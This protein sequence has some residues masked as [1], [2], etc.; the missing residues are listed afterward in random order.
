M[1]KNNYFILVWHH[2]VEEN[3]KLE[4]HCICYFDKN[5]FPLNNK[6]KN[7]FIFSSNDKNLKYNDTKEKKKTKQSYC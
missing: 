1:T 4:K 5:R 3:A 6:I 2:N 7:G